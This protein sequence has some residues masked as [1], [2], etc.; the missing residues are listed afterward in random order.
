MSFIPQKIKKNLP[1]LQVY[2]QPFWPL[3]RRPPLRSLHRQKGGA[4]GVLQ[5]IQCILHPAGGMERGPMGNLRAAEEG[6]PEGIQLV[7]SR[8]RKEM[9][10]SERKKYV[11][12]K[13]SKRKSVQ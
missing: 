3:S 13:R 1:P 7:I 10:M 6:G 9:I 2:E 11:V 8:E 5:G 4:H 12:E